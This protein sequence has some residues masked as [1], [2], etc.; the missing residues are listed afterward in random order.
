MVECV[1][2]HY[3]KRGHP[4]WNG[5]NPLAA[6]R[7]YLDLSFVDRTRLISCLLEWT[8][9]DSKLVREKIEEAYKNRTA[10]KTYTYNPYEL[11]N[12]GQDDKKHTY[13][14]MKGNNTRFRLY[15]QT[16]ITKKPSRWLSVCDTLKG[17]REYTARLSDSAKTVRCRKIVDDLASIHIP[18]I[19]RAEE[20]RAQAESRRQRSEYERARRAAFATQAAEMQLDRGSRT[21]GNRV[22]YNS[23]LEGRSES[24]D[25]SP[26]RSRPDSP[27]ENAASTR[28][29][30]MLKRPRDWDD[31]QGE[32]LDR[33]IA[34][35]LAESEEPESRIVIL[36]YN[37]SKY[38]TKAPD[39]QAYTNGA[40]HTE[41]TAKTVEATNSAVSTSAPPTTPQ[42][43][44]VEQTEQTEQIAHDMKTHALIIASLPDD[45]T[46]E[47]LLPVIRKAIESC[48]N[49]KTTGLDILLH[50]GQV[51]LA[52]VGGFFT[53][54]QKVVSTLYVQSTKVCAEN[55]VDL[56][57]TV[58]I[59]KWCGYELAQEPIAW[60]VLCA[61]EQDAH[62]A[63][64]F[65]ARAA[66]CAIVMTLPIT[67]PVLN[68]RVHP[69]GKSYETVAVG[70]T[71][72]HIHAGHKIL[73]TMTA[74]LATRRVVCGITDDEL[75]K[76]KKYKEVMQNI[77]ERTS[78]TKQFFH[79]IKRDL[80]Y[81]FPA[82]NDVAGPT[83]SDASIQALVASRETEAGSAQI[84]EIRQKN[85]LP[86]LDIHFIDVVG[87]NGL[88]EGAEMA[89][90]KLSSTLIRERIARRE[91]KV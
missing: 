8:L 38:S 25:R 75:L 42:T 39:Q 83:A 5:T 44:T 3:E 9:T 27:D 73:L 22:D 21:R 40:S 89:S 51:P 31:T 50:L 88:V 26:R 74:W 70:G 15:V 34:A 53:A 14:L 48:V 37:K 16:D 59:D 19:E 29:G 1:T 78:D 52:N 69:A 24:D 35:S 4:A 82:I 36:K 7:R 87:P 63:S 55:H 20:Y 54:I 6:N 77:N 45:L 85:G 41:S 60:S 71:F 32:L 62:L 12:I 66:N 64:S 13:Y 79:R 28:S 56:D 84:T 81:T 49:T 46:V 67:K 30:R 90:L 65:K 17:L 91:S 33:A 86:P 80:S 61:T 2:Q 72:D 43:T 76:N 18:E 10:S 57:T 11:R 23:M 47:Y 58:I 68:S